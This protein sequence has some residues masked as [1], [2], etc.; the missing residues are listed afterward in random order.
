L[1]GEFEKYGL[2]LAFENGKQTFS[3]AA[4]VIAGKNS[5]RASGKDFTLGDDFIPFNFSSN[6]TV[7]AEVVFAG[8]GIIIKNDTLNWDNYEGLDVKDKWVLIFRDLPPLLRSSPSLKNNYSD[9]D[10]VIQAKDLGA[11]GVLLVSPSFLN[12]KDELTLLKRYQSVTGIPAIHITRE[13]AGFLLSGKAES[14]IRLEGISPDSASTGFSS[15]VTIAATTELVTEFVSTA[16]VIGYLKGKDSLLQDEFIVIG[17]HYDHLG[18]G[19]YGSSSRHPDTIAVHYGADDNAS[20]VASVLELAAWF[21]SR[22]QDFRR[23]LVFILFGA[24]EKGILGSVY[25]TE[26]PVFPM[27]K[28]KMMFNID[29]LGRMRPDSTLSVGGTG[30]TAD[31]EDILKTINNNYGFNLQLNSAGYG[32]SDH[33]SFYSKDVPVLFFTTGGH[34]DYHT[35][36]DRIDSLNLSGQTAITKYIASL[37][38]Y[39]SVIDTLPAF[40]EAG[41]KTA[42]SISMQGR[43]TLGIMPDV[44][45]ERTQGVKVLAV[46]PGRPAAAGGIQKEDIIVALDGKEVNSIYEYMFRLNQLSPGQL[47]IVTVLRRNQHIELLIQL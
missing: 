46:T 43:V 31:S 11:A 25:Y 8:F 26:N 39:L 40:T 42:S 3:Y 47:I 24:E 36:D 41:P 1:A 37:I 12:Q 17:A 20:G 27:E 38:S 22:K 10:K 21:S 33:A 14:L 35:P 23:S 2:S 16:N 34:Q 28:T 4:G 19:G 7:S 13:L 5:L 30:T 44:S 29:M 32:P 18:M 45:D 6:A 15:G 9:R